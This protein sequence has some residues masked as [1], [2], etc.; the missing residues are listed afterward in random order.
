[1]VICETFRAVYGCQ[2][3]RLLLFDKG[4]DTSPGC[5]RRPD[6]RSHPGWPRAAARN[7]SVRR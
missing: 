7:Q 2:R 4:K 5:L 6:K 1:M 3:Q